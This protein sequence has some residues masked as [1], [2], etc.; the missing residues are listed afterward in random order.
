[1]TPLEIFR[2]IWT[3]KITV[4]FVEAVNFPSDTNGF[5]DEW[6]AAIY[7]STSRTRITIDP[8]PFV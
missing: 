3:E 6:A 1:M 7:Q 5:P 4:Q 2:S 8:N